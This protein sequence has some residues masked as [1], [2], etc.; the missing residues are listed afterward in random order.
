MLLADVYSRYQRLRGHEVLFIC[1]TDEHGTPAELAA[2][3]AGLEVS[4]YCRRHTNSSQKEIYEQFSLS[5]EHF[6][7]SSS[8][9]N[10]DLTQHFARQL[11]AQGF[12]EERETKQI[13]S[14][15]DGRF[16]PDR[17]VIGTCPYCGYTAARGDQCEN[18]TACW[19]Q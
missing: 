11:D 2:R 15:A 19:T 14:I 13:Y 3:D 18:R 8:A 10:A 12:I 6:G 4:E 17:Y 16:I 5:F 9:Q 1:A 7:R